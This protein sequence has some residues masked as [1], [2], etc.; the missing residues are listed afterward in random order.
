VLKAKAALQKVPPRSFASFSPREFVEV[1]HQMKPTPALRSRRDSPLKAAVDVHAEASSAGSPHT[2]P[3]VRSAEARRSSARGSPPRR[4]CGKELLGT[5]LTLTV[6]VHEARGRGGPVNV[7]FREE[8]A[9]V[10]H[11]K[12]PPSKVSPVGL[13]GSHK[14]EL[15]H[16]RRNVVLLS[17]K[18]G[19][20]SSKKASPKGA[21]RNPTVLLRGDDFTGEMVLLLSPKGPAERE[22]EV[23]DWLVRTAKRTAAVE[24]A[25]RAAV[26]VAHSAAHAAAVASIEAARAL[27]DRRGDVD[28]PGMLRDAA[29][30][31]SAASGTGASRPSGANALAT[32]SASSRAH[33][34]AIGAVRSAGEGGA[35]TRILGSP[36]ARSPGV[37]S[38]RAWTPGRPADVAGWSP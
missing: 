20:A 18:G 9:R 2:V 11:Q 24:R 4:A 1:A 29:L 27:R 36:A 25:R 14:R 13:L 33:S 8:S 38:P 32:L 16:Q 6:S 35:H 7:R 37:D 26:D 10:H 22:E 3:A 34:P 5:A 28:M 19:A 17:P 15:L 21:A 23:P 31:L 30:S 12:P